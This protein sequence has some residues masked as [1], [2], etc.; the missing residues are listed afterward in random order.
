MDSESGAKYITAT[1]DDVLLVHAVA[2]KYAVD[3]MASII[4]A[5]ND[6][7]EI[8]YMSTS[9]VNKNS[10]V[11]NEN[12][13]GLVLNNR[14]KNVTT[15]GYEQFTAYNRNFVHDFVKHNSAPLSDRENFV[16]IKTHLTNYLKNNGIELSDKEYVQLFDKLK[17]KQYFSQITEDIIVGDKVIKADVLRES[18][19]Q[20]NIDLAGKML[21]GE[22]S[23]NE[24]TSI[25]DRVR[26]IFARV[27]NIADVKP[28]VK[29]FAKENNLDIILLGKPTEFENF[30][31]NPKYIEELN[32]LKTQ[33][34]NGEIS[35]NDFYTKRDT[36]NAKYTEID[37]LNK[38]SLMARTTSQQE[39]DKAA[40][41]KKPY[42]RP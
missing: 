22:S 16:F 31:S 17:G 5:T 1:Q 35:G 19:E 7:T 8:T 33:L 14:S 24:V 27:D 3:S 18:L 37:K 29:V 40:A 34:A 2:D 36:L 32:V 30:K 26:G 25:V 12:I 10:A 21:Y 42:T 38:K 15:A 11:F 6:P 9:L 23:N 39:A 4:K 13:Y 28:E 20:S 41:S